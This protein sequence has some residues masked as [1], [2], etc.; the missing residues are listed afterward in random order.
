VGGNAGAQ[1]CGANRLIKKTLYQAAGVREYVAVLLEEQQV[2]WHRLVKGAYRLCRPDSQG[3]FRSR[4]FPG[5]WLDAPAVWEFDLARL[6]ATLQR[7]LKSPGHTAFVQKL[8]GRGN[9]A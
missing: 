1:V 2:R 5:L 8:A 6:P 3:V 7:G 9:G 4:E